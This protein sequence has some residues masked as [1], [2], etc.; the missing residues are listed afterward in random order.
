[1]ARTRS[2]RD[3]ERGNLADK[4]ITSD[5]YMH[6]LRAKSARRGRYGVTV[7]EPFNFEIRDQQAKHANTR[8]RKVNEMVMEKK[9]EEENMITH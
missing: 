7:P 4:R 6:K 3:F 8:E 5:D 9:M 1:M 2:T